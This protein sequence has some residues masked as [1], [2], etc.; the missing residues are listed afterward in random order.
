MPRFAANLHSLFTEATVLER[1][2]AA[3]RAGCKE[4]EL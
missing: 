3:A 2:D 4:V 1:F